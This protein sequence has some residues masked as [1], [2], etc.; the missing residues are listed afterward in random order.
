[1]AYNVQQIEEDLEN[2]EDGEGGAEDVVKKVVPS[3]APDWTELGE[4][5][6][7]DP[8][9]M[10]ALCISLYQSLVPGISNVTLRIRYYGFYAWLSWRYSVEVRD[11]STLGWRRYLRR[12]EALCALVSRHANQTEAGISGSIWARRMLR[13][14]QDVLEFNQATDQGKD[15]P[16]YLR[17]A[18]GAFGAAYGAQ[19]EEIGLLEKVAEKHTIPLVSKDG[20]QMAR[21][22]AESVGV[23][24]EKFLR[25]AAAGGVTRAELTELAPMSF[26]RITDAERQAYETLLFGQ[27]AQ[28]SKTNK[29]R[30]LTLELVLRL[31]GKLGKELNANDIRW[32]AYSGRTT[33]GE[34]LDLPGEAL[35]E[36]RFEWS[37]YHA[38]DL[39]HMAY[40]GLFK[41][42]LQRL[43]KHPAGLRP[44]TL[45][46][47]VVTDLMANWED[48]AGTWRELE[49]NLSL[50]E[51]AWSKSERL[52]D[53]R[54]ANSVLAS[55][56]PTVECTVESARA[57]LLLLV[58]LAKRLKP[59]AEKCTTVLGP[60]ALHP[61][62]QSLHSELW[63]L[64]DQADASLDALLQT[65]LLRRII[66]RHFWVAFQKLR[67]QR[68]YTFLLESQDGVLRTRKVDGPMLTN[69][70]LESTVDFLRD[71]GLVER[72]GL[73]AAGRALVE[74]L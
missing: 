71:I 43:A 16:Q 32:A 3:A 57:A 72:K 40:E 13:S 46:R 27:S 19:V 4:K 25:V 14:D 26:G 66:D 15:T 49:D 52:S 69:P 28:D 35:E 38:N 34:L 9:G 64:A 31:T 44:E 42:T 50:A 11:G 36:H 73:T 60:S 70:R 67:F 56:G 10:Q 54:L 6:G 5:Q 29:R 8:L 59:L 58:V 61:F 55:A 18:N 7:Q 24:G 12:A 63:F 30:R 23:A 65:L 2:D 33:D 62:V 47:Y 37:V 39:L 22:F 48:A 45:L 51:D 53:Y 17:Q 20:L 21:V 1:L 74:K 68:G 41:F